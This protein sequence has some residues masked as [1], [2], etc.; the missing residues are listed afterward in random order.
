MYYR[1]DTWSK[2]GINEHSE[3]RREIV[4]AHENEHEV[5]GASGHRALAHFHFLIQFL[6][7]SL[8]D[9]VNSRQLPVFGYLSVIPNVL[10]KIYL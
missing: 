4:L 9:L 1:D 8:N 5:P 2:T 6:A 3:I 7:E 10:L